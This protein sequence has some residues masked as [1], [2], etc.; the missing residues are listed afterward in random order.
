M[1]N[2]YGKVFIDNVEVLEQKCS[3]TIIRKAL[4]VFSCSKILLVFLIWWYL[5]LKHGNYQIG[6]VSI[7]K[8]RKCLTK[9]F[10]QFI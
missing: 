4:G 2:L 8:L 5:G 10:T 3:N 6:F 7:T 9:Y 1:D